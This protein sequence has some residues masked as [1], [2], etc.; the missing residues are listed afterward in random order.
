MESISINKSLWIRVQPH[1]V[2]FD[3]E[4]L[5]DKVHF[6]IAFNK[7]SEYINLHLSKNV[8]G[9]LSKDKPQIKICRILK[10]DIELLIPEIGLD[11]LRSVLKK[12]DVKS[13]QYL[14]SY[15]IPFD[16]LETEKHQQIF[17]KAFIDGFE[18][19]THIKRNKKLYVKGNVGKQIIEVVESDELQDSTQSTIKLFNPNDFQNLKGGFIL[20]DNSKPL[21][22]L[23]INDDWYGMDF[24]TNPLSYLELIMGKELT[25]NLIDYTKESINTI[26]DLTTKEECKEYENPIHFERIENK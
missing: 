26:K 13:H 6:T 24:N 1:Q 2:N 18:T 4:G 12:I 9:V 16:D 15:I 23:K 22:I 11:I 19:L 5:P 17:Q 10:K 3:Y 25:Q 20:N 8:K 14:N 21:G 7:K